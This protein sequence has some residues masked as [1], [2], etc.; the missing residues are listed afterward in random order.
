M[1]S[2]SSASS[3]SGFTASASSISARSSTPSRTTALS[4]SRGNAATETVWA[5]TSPELHQ[6]VT[7]QRGWSRR[8]YANWLAE[9]LEEL[10]LQR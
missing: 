10:L 5:L 9:S 6:L 1:Q 2:P 8:R 4:A 3:S 7:N